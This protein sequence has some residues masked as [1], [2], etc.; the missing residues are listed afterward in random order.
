MRRVHVPEWIVIESRGRNAPPQL[1]FVSTTFR[2][3]KEQLVSSAVSKG[4][5]S[6]PGNFGYETQ[7]GVEA[8]LELHEEWSLA[9]GEIDT[10]NETFT[11]D[12]SAGVLA[13]NGAHW[14]TGIR[15]PRRYL[16]RMG[17]PALTYSSLAH[18]HLPCHRSRPSIAPKS[19]LKGTETTCLCVV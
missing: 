13:V 11:K 19:H 9:V 17:F 5:F 15:V 7:R 12:G 6:L 14:I 10:A 2:S 18:R 3:G 4:G 1:N 8:T 16:C